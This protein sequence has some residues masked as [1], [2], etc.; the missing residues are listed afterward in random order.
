MMTERPNGKTRNSEERSMAPRRLPWHRATLPTTAPRP[1]AHRIM[2]VYSLQSCHGVVVAPLSE[3]LQGR[4]LSKFPVIKL[5]LASYP[6][7]N[8][9]SRV[10]VS[11]K[12]VIFFLFVRVDWVF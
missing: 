7:A 1:M 6:L 12:N 4:F 3:M 11:S 9:Y 5:H 10:T 8:S 2:H